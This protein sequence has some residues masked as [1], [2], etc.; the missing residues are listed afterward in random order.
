VANVEEVFYLDFREWASPYT[1]HS[2]HFITIPTGVCMRPFLVLAFTLTMLGCAITPQQAI[3]QSAKNTVYAELFG[4][5]GYGGVSFNYDRLLSRNVALRVGINPF[6]ST[7]PITA[8]YL[9]DLGGPSNLEFGGGLT[10]GFGGGFFG[11]GIAGVRR[12][13]FLQSGNHALFRCQFIC[14]SVRYW[15]WLYVPVEKYSRML[16]C[17]GRVVSSR[18][19]QCLQF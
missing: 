3:A 16:T 4:N 6:I 8:S 18:F 10:I 14:R 11:T 15:R 2:P 19:D 13:D 9:V 12:R 5:A 7:I 17:L 1:T